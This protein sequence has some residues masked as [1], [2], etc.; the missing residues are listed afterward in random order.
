MTK[1]RVLA[2]IIALGMCVSQ[3]ACS[4]EISDS[5]I[6]VQ[7]KSGI[8]IF[9]EERVIEEACIEQYIMYD[10]DTMVMYT[11]ISKGYDDGVVFNIMYNADGTPKLYSPYTDTEQ[12]SAPSGDFY[13]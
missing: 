12:V 1:R 7:S 8:F 9:V 10:P 11:Y 2:M 13:F 4:G 5:D 6:D 3:P